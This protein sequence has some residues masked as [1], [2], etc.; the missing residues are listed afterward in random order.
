MSGAVNLNLG[1]PC[2]ELG[3]KAA[4]H[5]LTVHQS[6]HFTL[7]RMRVQLHTSRCSTS[8][9]CLLPSLARAAL[10]A[11]GL[12]SQRTRFLSVG[13]FFVARPSVRRTHS[14]RMGTMTILVIPVPPISLTLALA[15]S[16]AAKEE[17]VAALSPA[18]PF[19]VS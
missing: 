11:Q 5:F 3:R 7:C 12:I 2:P 15:V 4:V 14:I 17:R 6:G 1:S 16:M 9:S 13:N 18:S 8:V 10:T 19:W